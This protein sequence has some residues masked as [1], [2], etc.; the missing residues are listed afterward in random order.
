MPLDFPRFFFGEQAAN[1]TK[2]WNNVEGSLAM[3]PAHSQ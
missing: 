2:I 1:P 3:L